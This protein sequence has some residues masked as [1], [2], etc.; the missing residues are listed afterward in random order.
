MSVYLGYYLN[1]EKSQ[2]AGEDLPSLKEIKSNYI[3]YLLN[4]TGN[5]LEETAKILDVP[6][7]SLEKDI[8]G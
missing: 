5:D 4:V 6:R 7:A 3:Q 1:R 8:N 2:K